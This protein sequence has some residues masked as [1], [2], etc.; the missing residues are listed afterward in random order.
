MKKKRLPIAKTPARTNMD[1]L[2]G[3]FLKDCFSKKEK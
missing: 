2:S 3:N 1:A